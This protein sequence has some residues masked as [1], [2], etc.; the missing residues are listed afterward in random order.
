MSKEPLTARVLRLVGRHLGDGA[1]V[2][3][4]VVE[5]LSLAFKV[6]TFSM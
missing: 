5:V 6:H 2:N 1:K 3:A 4:D